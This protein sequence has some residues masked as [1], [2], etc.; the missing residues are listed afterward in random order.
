MKYSHTFL[1]VPKG[2]DIYHS[3]VYKEYTMKNKAARAAPEYRIGGRHQ[4]LICADH[5]QKVKH[6][7][8][9]HAEAVKPVRIPMKPVPVAV[10]RQFDQRKNKAA[11]N[12]YQNDF[13][14]VFLPYKCLIKK[15]PPATHFYK[16]KKIVQEV[17]GSCTQ[18]KS[19]HYPL[20]QYRD[21]QQYK[22]DF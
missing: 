14:C 4:D 1:V 15:S 13:L 8:Q 21:Q 17:T 6:T 19:N 2:R 9:D 22:D 16:R 11:A 3:K 5:A 10:N 20:I 12:Q 18:F 7:K